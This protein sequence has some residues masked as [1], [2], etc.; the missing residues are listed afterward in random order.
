MPLVKLT[1]RDEPFD[2]PEDELD[3]LRSQGLLEG[4]PQDPPAPAQPRPA[5]PPAAETPKD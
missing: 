4:E 5:A 2:V 3:T 1:I